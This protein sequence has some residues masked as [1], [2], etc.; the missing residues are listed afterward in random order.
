MKKLFAVIAFGLLF[1]MVNAQEL[2]L[3]VEELEVKY[4][5]KTIDAKEPMERKI[6]EDQK[7]EVLIYEVDGYKFISVFE[8]FRSNNR[9]KMTVRNMVRTPDGKEV[10]GKVKKYVQFIKVGIPGEFSKNMSESIVFDKQNFLALTAS[11][12]FTIKYAYN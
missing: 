8:Y 5:G 1:S 2:P 3:I 7:S 4:K 11:Y 9:V 6:V 12:K 10:R